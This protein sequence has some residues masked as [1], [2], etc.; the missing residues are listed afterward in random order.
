[1]A[2]DDSRLASAHDAVT[3]LRSGANDMQ[4]LTNLTPLSAD[5]PE[6]AVD[7]GAA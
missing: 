4:L 6:Q 2:H 1:M 5:R 7:S 3:D